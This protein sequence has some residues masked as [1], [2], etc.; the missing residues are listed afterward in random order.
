M[1][2]YHIIS[3]KP[4]DLAIINGII[5][6]QKKIKLSDDAVEKINKCRNYLDKKLASHKKP[7]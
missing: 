3:S 7:I 4:I 6:E 5:I 2:S 1:D